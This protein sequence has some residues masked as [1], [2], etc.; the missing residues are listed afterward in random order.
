MVSTMVDYYGLPLDGR[1]AWPCS[2]P[3]GAGP[4][5]LLV[6]EGMRTDIAT[7]GIGLARRFIPYVAMYEFEALLFSDCSTFGRS[8][9]REDIVSD[10]E[11]IRRAFVS[12]EAIDD[13]PTG[14]PSKRIARLIA[15]Y[16]KPFH[17]NIAALEI[18]V[19]KMRA[20]CPHFAEWL[21]A[22]EGVVATLAA[23]RRP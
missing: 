19:E 22:L 12:P 21:D 15:D 5:A 14:A 20:E 16:N 7:E 9:E 2:V 4:E 18:G 17:G 6:E 1:R 11:R 10:L 13:S 3:R 23:T 8:I